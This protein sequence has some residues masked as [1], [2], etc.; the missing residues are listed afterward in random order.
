MTM[1]QKTTARAWLAAAASALAMAA[2]MAHAQTAEQTKKLVATG[3]QFAASDAHVSMALCGAD[4]KRVEEMK[5]NA[6]REFADDPNF[7]A[8]WAR[9]WQAA[10]RTITGANE[11]KAKNPS[12]YASTRE[13]I[14][15][16]AMAPKS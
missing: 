8:D 13:D 16:D 6:K 4:A 12:E 2:Q 7:E 14:C 5:A 1:M 11:V 9:G 15:R 10:Q 3:V